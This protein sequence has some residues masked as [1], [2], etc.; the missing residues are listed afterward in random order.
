MGTT[1][2]MTAI[3]F[4]CGGADSG[5]CRGAQDRPVVGDWCWSLICLC[6]CMLLLQHAAADPAGK[7]CCCTTAPP[8][9]S[10]AV[11]FASAYFQC[12]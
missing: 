4:F 5:G 12:S 6:C 9:S 7:S 11:D 3:V 1:K 10:F 8:A 2:K